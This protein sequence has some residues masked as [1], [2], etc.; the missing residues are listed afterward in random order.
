MSVSSALVSQTVSNTDA[1][2]D[3]TSSGFGTPQVAIVSIVDDIQPTDSTAQHS[4][5]FF[6]GTRTRC[7]AYRDSDGQATTSSGHRMSNDECIFY[8]SGSILARFTLSF[9][10]DGLR[11]TRV[12]NN[13]GSIRVFVTL[14]KGLDSYRVDHVTPDLTS[15]NSVA[16]TDPGFQ[17]DALIFI[18][19]RNTFQSGFGTEN[20]HAEIAM[21][22]S[23]N[24]DSAI[25]QTCMNWGSIN[26]Q[27]D[28]NV[29][30]RLQSDRISGPE[31]FGDD[32]QE[33]EVT[34]Y[35]A[36]GFTITS[37]SNSGA[38]QDH[39]YIALKFDAGDGAEIHTGQ[40]PASSGAD[41]ISGLDVAPELVLVTAGLASALD[42]T[43][44][45]GPDC[46][47]FM[48]SQF[49]SSDEFTQG[50]ESEDNVATSNTCCFSGSYAHLT[51]AGACALANRAS[52]TSLNSDGWTWNFDTVNQA[53]RYYTSLA[54]GAEAAA[55]RVFDFMPFMPLY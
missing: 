23:T 50:V 34:A 29:Y 45:A 7:L 9:I 4:V 44:N 24:R 6:D 10:T 49:N 11:L 39:G 36:S 42:T 47:P 51:Y 8:E 52:L 28:S 37:R 33:V 20:A 46:E 40:V 35:G 5:T 15:G 25:Q 43:E 32:I 3:F 41:T 2:K 53:S 17:P 30:S 48:F 38:S 14:I 54:I 16:T 18:A 19:A 21:G 1:T 13:Y 55:G 26:G 31:L 22:F 27:A 12:S